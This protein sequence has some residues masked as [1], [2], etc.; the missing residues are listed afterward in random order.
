MPRRTRCA[1]GTAPCPGPS[2]GPRQL[3]LRGA[4]FPWRTITGAECSAYWPAGTAAFHVNAD[5]A[6]AVARYADATGDD[7]FD[8]QTGCDLLVH[9]ARLWFS[10]GHAGRAASGSTG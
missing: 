1:G 5:I 9:T 4:A 3:G 7:Q 10:L 2:T 6:H 8:R